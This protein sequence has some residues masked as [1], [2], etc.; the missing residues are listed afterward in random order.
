MGDPIN[1]QGVPPRNK[2]PKSPRKACEPLEPGI[3]AGL[4]C[5]LHYFDARNGVFPHPQAGQGS[6]E[7]GFGFQALERTVRPAPCTPEC[8]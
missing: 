5:F 1:L 6:H 7:P 4:E 2:L 8:P 3:V